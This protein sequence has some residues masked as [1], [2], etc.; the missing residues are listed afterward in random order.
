MYIYTRHEIILYTNPIT[1]RAWLYCIDEWTMILKWIEN[2]CYEVYKDVLRAHTHYFWLRES[3]LAEMKTL[4]P[5]FDLI[6]YKYLL[7]KLLSKYLYFKLTQLTFMIQFD[8][9]TLNKMQFWHLFSVVFFLGGGLFY[10]FYFCWFLGLFLKVIC[11]H[12][13]EQNV[14]FFIKS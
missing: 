2:S 9:S 11:L 13:W 14:I 10:L 8:F 4:N 12:F 5:C 7:T 3:P 1:N 6:L